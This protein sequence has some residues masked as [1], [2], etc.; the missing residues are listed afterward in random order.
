MQNSK[1][2]CIDFLIKRSSG[3]LWRKDK[4]MRIKSYFILVK[5]N[6]SNK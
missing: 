3:F 1:N 2:L 5:S 4:R 6:K